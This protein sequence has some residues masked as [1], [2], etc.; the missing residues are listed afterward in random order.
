MNVPMIIAVGIILY[1]LLLLWGAWLDHNLFPH[2]VPG[3]RK[4]SHL[5]WTGK[6]GIFLDEDGRLVNMRPDK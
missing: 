3:H 2:G 6:D 4:V 5:S 1:L